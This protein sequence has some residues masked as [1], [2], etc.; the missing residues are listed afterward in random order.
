MSSFRLDK[1]AHWAGKVSEQSGRDMKYWGEKSIE[2][3][4]QAAWYLTCKAYGLDPE[5][6][7]RLDK[8]VFSMRKHPV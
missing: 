8:T 5:K 3:R 4:L 7:L 6:P 2:E 1:T